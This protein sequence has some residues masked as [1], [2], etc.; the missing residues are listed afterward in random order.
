MLYAPLL[1]GA[2]AGT[3]DP[4]HVVVPLREELHTTDLRLGQVVGARPEENVLEVRS[5]KGDIEG[6][7]YDQLIVALGSVSRTLPVPGLAEHGFGFKTL[8]DAIALRNRI[9]QTLEI[10]ETLEDG[11]ERA[12]WLSYVFVGAGYAGLEGL[13]ELQDFAADAIELYPRCRTSGMRWLLVEAQDRVMPEIPPQLAEFASA[14]L[15]RRGIEI[16]TQ[17][18]LERMDE[19]SAL[20]SGGETV[21]ART[22]VWTAGVR[23]PAVIERLGLPLD[24]GRI[25]TDGAMRVEGRRNVWAIGDCAAV[26]DPA[27]R[28][29]RASPP[30]AQ[31]AIRQGRRVAR[32]VAAELGKGQ[33]RPFRYR[34]LGVFVDMGQGEAVATTLGIRWRGRKAWWLARTYHL[35]MMPGAKRRLR[36]LVDWNI[37]VLFG[38]DASELGRLGHPERL[39][40]HTAGGDG[41]P[42]DGR[43]EAAPIE[44]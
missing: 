19:R 13:A 44:R 39:V 42:G 8:P 37:Q 15:R 35:A 27:F 38:R 40:D 34:T 16:R 21:P 23:P 32:N 18:T 36:L 6:L 1:P 11:R 31:H 28:A 7:R 26:P 10:A 9:L 22:I 3:L 4:R 24:R 20:L 33:V 29:K 14:E 41:A 30:T 12:E 5:P 43:P 25:R 17:T 2:A